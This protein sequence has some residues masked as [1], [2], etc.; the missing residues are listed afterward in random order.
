LLLRSLSRDNPETE[1]AEVLT[2]TEIE[3]LQTTS[4]VQFSD[5]PTVK[6]VMQ[7][8]A[9]LGGHIKSN[10]PPGWLVLWRGYQ[11]LKTM[12]LGWTARGGKC[13]L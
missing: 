7:A 5:K 2:S 13:D 1:A 12:E 6:E 10:G 8:I 11:K 4:K 9:R 3:I